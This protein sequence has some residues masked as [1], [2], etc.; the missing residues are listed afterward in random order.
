MDEPTSVLTPQA[1]RKLFETLR[2]LADEGC[3]ILY[4]SHKLDEVRELCHNATVL[5]GG[6]VT[7]HCVP[8]PRDAGLHG[9]DDD[10]QGTGGLPARRAGRARRGA[11]RAARAHAAR[12]APLRRRAAGRGA[13]SARGRD[14]RH[15]GRVGQWAAGTAAGPLRRGAAAARGR[16]IRVAGRPA[17]GPPG[18]RRAPRAR[19]GLR[20]GGAAGPR[21]R[22]GDEPGRQRPA[23]GAS[24]GPGAAR[25]GPAR[26]GARLRAALHRRIRGQMRRTAGAGRCAVGRQP[27]EV[28]RRARAA[29]APARAR[30]G[31]AHLGRGCRRGGLHPPVADRA[32]RRGCGAAGGVGRAGRAVRG[33]RPDRG[34]GQRAVVAG[35]AHATDRRGNHRPVDERHVARGRRRRRCRC[36]R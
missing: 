1:V 19:P 4:I 22:A 17:G 12:A 16:R 14:R 31:A 29:A 26:R 9:A 5:R 15:R 30:G 10:R 33:L 36:P 2:Q 7:G 28:H 21:R 35:R 27:A 34:D 13:G 25:P 11:A 8:A 6:R 32:A 23:D 3:S 24:A 18:Q 20:A